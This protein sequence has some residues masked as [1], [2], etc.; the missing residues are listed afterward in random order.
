MMASLKTLGHCGAQEISY[1]VWA[2][3]GLC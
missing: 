1:I 2:E 3:K